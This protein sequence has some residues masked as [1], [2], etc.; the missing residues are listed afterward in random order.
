MGASFGNVNADSVELLN[1]QMGTIWDVVELN[2][3]TVT[4]IGGDI[5]GCFI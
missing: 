3:V 2:I 4:E 1:S 5:Y